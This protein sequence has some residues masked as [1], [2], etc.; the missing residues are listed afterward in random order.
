MD[1]DELRQEEQGEGKRVS[2]HANQNPR[3]KRDWSL[4]K[5]SG[6]RRV[7]VSRAGAEGEKECHCAGRNLE[8]R[9]RDW[10][11]REDDGH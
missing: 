6:R 8:G 3:E 11:L 1:T 2:H 4:R 7:K 5:D 9:E 10:S